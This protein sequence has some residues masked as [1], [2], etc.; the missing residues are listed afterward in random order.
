M[1]GIAKFSDN[2]NLHT[3]TVQCM[4]YLSDNGVLHLNQIE[5]MKHQNPV[6]LRAETSAGYILGRTIKTHVYKTH[7]QQH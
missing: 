1:H 5:Q 2:G 3:S 4:A 7:K 6:K